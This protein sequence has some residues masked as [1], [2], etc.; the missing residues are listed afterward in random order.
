MQYL[1]TEITKITIMFQMDTCTKNPDFCG[2]FYV[3]KD[4]L[5][6]EQNTESVFER[7]CCRDNFY[8]NNIN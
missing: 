4:Q 5:H 7:W 3:K 6:L 8:N 1:N 2:L